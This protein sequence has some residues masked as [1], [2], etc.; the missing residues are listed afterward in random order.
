MNRWSFYQANYNAVHISL[1]DQF[2]WNSMKYTIIISE[3]INATGI[4]T[5][6]SLAC[7]A[8]SMQ[9]YLISRAGYSRSRKHN[10][11][12]QPDLL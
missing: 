8:C 11:D 5:R 6:E 2:S 7:W 3:L 12:A 1:S 10:L 9:E 4:T